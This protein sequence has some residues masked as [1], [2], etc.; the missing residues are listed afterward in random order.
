MRQ[1]LKRKPSEPFAEFLSRILSET[2]P[3]ENDGLSG[4]PAQY[5]RYRLGTSCPVPHSDAMLLIHSYLAETIL[6]VDLIVQ[7]KKIIPAFGIMR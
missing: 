5:C 7:R 4:A 1:A 2:L 3:V 6:D